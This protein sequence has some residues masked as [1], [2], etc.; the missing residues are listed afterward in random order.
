[1]PLVRQRRATVLVPPSSQVQNLSSSEEE[2]VK[3]DQIGVR[4]E[5]PKG[6][7]GQKYVRRRKDNWGDPALLEGHEGR[8][9]GGDCAP[10][11]G[12]GDSGGRGGRVGHT[13]ACTFLLLLH[14]FPLSFLVL[15]FLADPGGRRGGSPAMAAGYRE[16]SRGS[17]GWERE[18]LGEVKKPPL[19][20]WPTGVHIH[21]RINIL[22]AH[23]HKLASQKLPII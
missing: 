7:F 19:L 4:M 10:G 5:T 8:M 3:G 23:T 18:G 21:G 15:I 2:N 17:V 6:P 22:I 9:N 16:A 12:G 11:G 1:M 13:L 20:Q 14:I